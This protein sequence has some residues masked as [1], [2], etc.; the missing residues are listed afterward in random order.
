M[1]AIR[2]KIAAWED[3]V[4]RAIA[5]VEAGVAGRVAKIKRAAPLPGLARGAESHPP[6]NPSQPDSC[7]AWCGSSA[8][9]A[10]GGQGGTRR[11]EAVGQSCPVGGAFVVRAFEPC[12]RTRCP[13]IGGHLLPCVQSESCAH[14]NRSQSALPGGEHMNPFGV[15]VTGARGAVLHMRPGRR[16]WLSGNGAPASPPSWCAQLHLG[17]SGIA[18][19]SICQVPS[20]CRTSPCLDS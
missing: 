12:D 4:R 20:R 3:A 16:R 15:G 13:D 10:A 9:L 8:Y 7:R 19:H 18:G 2:V 5:V 11:R 6:R 17:P 14:W 1:P